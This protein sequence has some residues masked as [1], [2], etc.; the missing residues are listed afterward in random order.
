MQFDRL[1]RRKFVTLIGGMAV[2][3][4]LA[5]QTQEAGRT[6]RIAGL[7]AAPRTDE[8]YVALFDELRR[9]GFAEGRNLGLPA[10]SPVPSGSRN[11]PPSSRERKS[12]SC[13]VVV[14]I[15]PFALRNRRA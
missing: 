6:Y 13:F 3:W 5:A 4:P 2:A 11:V 15:R 7:A 10:G 1:K 8:R 9:A 12:T 14:G